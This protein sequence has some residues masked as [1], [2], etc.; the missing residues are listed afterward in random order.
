MPFKIK[1]LFKVNDHDVT[2]KIMVLG[3]PVIASNLSRTIMNIADVAMVGHLGA[4]ALAATGMGSMLVWVILSIAIGLRTGTQTISSR[5]LGQKNYK[6]CGTALQTGLLLTL[7][8]MLP[9]SFLGFKTVSVFVPFFINDPEV[10]PLCIEYTSIAYI[11]IIFSSI[12]F[13]FQGFFTGIE[14]TK[15]HMKV[16]VSANLINVYLN[17]GFIYGT[18]GLQDFLD[19]NHLGWLG[20]LWG[21][22]N[23][24]A[25]GVKGAALA[26]VLASLWLMVH[27]FFYLFNGEMREKFAIFKLHFNWHIFKRQVSLALPQGFQEVIVTSGYAVFFKIVGLLGIT[28]LAATEVV[29]T[30]MHASFMP[31]LGIGQACATLVGKSLGEDKPEH[32]ELC[33]IESVRISF[34]IMGVTGIVFLIMPNLILSIFTNDPQVMAKGLMPLRIT[35]LVQFVDAVGLTLWFALAGAGNTKFPAVLE[36]ITM[37]GICLP[38]SYLAAIKWSWGLVGPWA[39][40]G[41]NILLFAGFMAWKVGKGDWKNIKI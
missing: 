1:Q 4:G 5:R 32:A 27:Y 11:S 22:A 29:F 6:E 28:A 2:S 24:P 10:T 19:S 3:L 26:T 13:V 7:L 38:L 23:F 25:L 18:R 9:I 20:W 17:A 14:K 16:T 34:W 36:T 37:W 30:I 31:G 8:I 12:G 40:F 35:G 39:A 41:L 15:I 33:I 21:W